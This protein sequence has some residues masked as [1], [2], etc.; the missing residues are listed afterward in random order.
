MLHKIA[1]HCN[2]SEHL[3]IRI[4]IF[5]NHCALLCIRIRKLLTEAT[6]A[7]L[8]S[9]SVSILEDVNNVEKA[10]YPLSHK[11]FIT[12]MEIDVLRP[13]GY[14]DESSE[15]DTTQVITA[16]SSSRGAITHGLNW[17]IR[18]SIY[19]L[20]FLQRVSTSPNCT[21]EQRKLF[22]EYKLSSMEDLR[23]LVE[24]VSF[25]LGR[26]YDVTMSFSELIFYVRDVL[27]RR[28]GPTDS[29]QDAI[30]EKLSE[31]TQ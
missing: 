24:R 11:S 12:E 14:D 18:V 15:K 10:T 29:L 21:W 4:C 26:P 9:S 8:L 31:S 19:V 30:I 1:D 7:E 2:P 20:G 3:H 25:Y 6:D 5:T 28:S 16:D 22:L 13:T 17:R 27:L 23:V